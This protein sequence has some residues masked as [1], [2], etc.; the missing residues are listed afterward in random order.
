M[1][2]RE[3][4]E[5]L[6]VSFGTVRTQCAAGTTVRLGSYSGRSG[7]SG[8]CNELSDSTPSQY[9]AIQEWQTITNGLGVFPT[10]KT[11]S[12][13]VS[14]L[15]LP[16]WGRGYLSKDSIFG[17]PVRCLSGSVWQP[18]GP[19]RNTTSQVSPPKRVILSHISHYRLLC[20]H[21]HAFI[22]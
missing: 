17:S 12:K 21:W 1:H 3:T 10:S 14:I 19:N 11:S 5:S 18:V 4:T 7:F 22:I 13:I 2:V 6:L 20:E 8:S 15:K 16:M 9:P